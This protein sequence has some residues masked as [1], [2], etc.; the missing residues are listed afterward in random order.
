VAKFETLGWADA[1]KVDGYGAPHT[2][3]EGVRECRQFASGL[4][5]LWLTVSQLDDGALLSWGSDHEDEVVYV[6]SGALEVDGRHCPT[7][8]AVVI[9]SGVT[10]ALRAVGPTE[11]CHFGHGDRAI[12][13][14]IYGD[15][16][17][18]GHGVHVLG[19]GAWYESGSREGVGARW[20][21]DS[22]CPTCRLTLLHV[23]QH[24]P[25]K[26]GP[27]HSHSADEIIYVVTGSIRFGATEYPSHTAVFIP[28]DI[29]YA[30]GGGPEGYG[31]LNYRAN[32]SEQ[33]YDRAQPP[34]LESA[35]ARGGRAVNDFR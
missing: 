1:P 12:T 26:K 20:F 29:R 7:D 9:E 30:L 22:S 35:T 5:D 18:D 17:L 33:I 15:P 21:A 2:K 31:F 19:P 16:S 11:V 27:P 13:G 4:F 10:T 34:V 32:A 3:A 23:A 25:D 28:A 6:I 14:G 24:E 8:G